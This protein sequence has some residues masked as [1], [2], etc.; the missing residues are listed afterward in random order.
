M[1]VGIDGGLDNDA[2]NLDE[3]AKDPFW[4]CRETAT[5]AGQPTGERVRLFLQMVDRRKTAVEIPLSGDVME[6]DGGG[7][8][9]K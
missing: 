6:F 5:S 4:P 9:I 8:R 1:E 2:T 7:R 3:P